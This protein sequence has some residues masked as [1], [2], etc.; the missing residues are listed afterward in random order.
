MARILPTS[1]CNFL[2]MSA[3]NPFGP[4]SPYQETNSKPLKPAHSS[5]VGMSGTD[6]MRWRLVTASA[7]VLP[8]CAGGKEESSGSHR[9]CVVLLMR[10]VNAGAVPR[11]VTTWVL[12]LASRLNSSTTRWLAEPTV[13]APKVN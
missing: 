4:H 5:T 1:V 3:G 12:S 10:S 7:L 13:D 11:Y 8:P 6:G 2:V 9:S